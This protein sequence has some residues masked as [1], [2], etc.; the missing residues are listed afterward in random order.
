VILTGLTG[1]KYGLTGY[2]LKVIILFVYPV[3]PVEKYFGGNN[4]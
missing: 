4:D 1:F 2:S 3:N